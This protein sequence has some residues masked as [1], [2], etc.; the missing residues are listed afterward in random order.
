MAVAGENGQRAKFAGKIR[1]RVMRT[2]TRTAGTR[3]I[4]EGAD[5]ETGEEQTVTIEAVDRNGAEYRARQMGLLVSGVRQAP[6]PIA[7]EA[8]RVPWMPGP[9]DTQEMTLS[10]LA[11][12]APSVPHSAN[13]S[14]VSNGPV[15]LH[16]P[17]PSRAEPAPLEGA[18]TVE[19]ASPRQSGAAS[20]F[21]ER[22]PE[23]KSLRIASMVLLVLAILSYIAGVATVTVNVMA[24]ATEMRS[25]GMST[26]NAILFCI[27]QLAAASSLIAVGALLHALSAG[28]V[29]LGDLARNSFRRC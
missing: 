13:H 22:P 10:T 2:M 19:Y 8:P 17:I 18:T 20:L 27:G 15:R 6:Q 5:A 11:A 9:G 7:A 28:C 24:L 29:A 23:Y 25:S 3:W 16:A 12:V 21:E 4:I 26:T 14:Q 1:R